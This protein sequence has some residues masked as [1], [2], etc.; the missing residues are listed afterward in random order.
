MSALCAVAGT[1]V[2]VIRSTSILLHTRSPAIYMCRDQDNTRSQ[3]SEMAV[4]NSITNIPGRYIPQHH[5]VSFESIFTN[6]E[7][8]WKSLKGIKE[9]NEVFL[10][11][12]TNPK[13][14]I[15]LFRSI[16]VAIVLNHTQECVTYCAKITSHQTFLRFS[17]CSMLLWCQ[18]NRL[19]H[20]KYI[21][22]YMF[23]IYIYI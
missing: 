12:K 6:S 14:I 3:S 8:A 1:N 18:R 21:Y 22:S 4:P 7:S 20:Y 23:I 5:Y 11:T 2:L 10:T 15:T 13:I 9:V 19:S 17:F 16:W